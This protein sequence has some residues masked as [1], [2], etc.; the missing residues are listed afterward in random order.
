MNYT[1]INSIVGWLLGL[2]AF[3]VYMLTIKYNTSFWE[4]VAIHKG[5]VKLYVP[6]YNAGTVFIFIYDVLYVLLLGNA[7]GTIVL[8]CSLCFGFKI[9][10]LYCCFSHFAI[11]IAES[12]KSVDLN[13]KPLISVVLW[14][15]IG[16]IIYCI[17][18][19]KLF[20]H[21]LK[22]FYALASLFNIIIYCFVL[23]S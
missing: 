15:V 19:N 10:F 21:V 2:A 4:S 3:L 6:Y 8:L 17:L 22:D 13:K 16:V 18:Y 11:K 9:V 1:K 12:N 7:V 14:G 5:P 20:N 23:H